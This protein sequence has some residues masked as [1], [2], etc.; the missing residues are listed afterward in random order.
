MQ[1]SLRRWNKKAINKKIKN[2]GLGLAPIK[3]LSLRSH[4]YRKTPLLK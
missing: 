4:E 1:Q 2:G 3:F